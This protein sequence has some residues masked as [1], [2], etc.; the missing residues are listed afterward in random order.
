MIKHS[1]LLRAG[2]LFPQVLSGHSA[3]VYNDFSQTY[4]ITK[5]ISILDAN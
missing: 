5:K 2:P 1:P 4:I 3:K